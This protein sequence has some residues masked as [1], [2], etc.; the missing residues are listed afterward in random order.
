MLT[1]GYCFQA[2]DARQRDL[3]RRR[4][5]RL[6]HRNR[7]RGRHRPAHPLPPPG[8]AARVVVDAA[9]ARWTVEATKRDANGREEPVSFT[10]NFLFSCAGYYRYSEGY[11]PEFAGRERFKGTI[12]HP[13]HWPEDLDYAGKRVVVIGS[14]RDRGD[15]G[16]DDGQD[17]GPR[18]DA[19]ALA[20]LHRLA[21]GRRRDR[22]FPAQGP[23]RELGLRDPALDATSCC[24][25]SSST[26]RASSRRR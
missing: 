11:T 13:Q 26:A 3:A 1:M 12:V 8:R 15:A 10:A 21:P 14:R 5:P 4:D 23:A 7:Q 25:A 17:R 19:A 24:S 9:T 18:D 22:E 16:P 6:R 2:L 20:H